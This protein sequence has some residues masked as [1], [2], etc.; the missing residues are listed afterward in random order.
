MCPGTLSKPAKLNEI[1]MS[2]IKLHLQASH[3]ILKGIEFS[4]PVVKR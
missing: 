3:D 1:E 2:A 4:W